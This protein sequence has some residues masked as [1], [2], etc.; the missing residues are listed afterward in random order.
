MKQ[1]K[2]V[3][4]LLGSIFLLVAVAGLTAS[5]NLQSSGESASVLSAANEDGVNLTKDLH[6]PAIAIVSHI[7]HDFVT[8]IDLETNQVTDTIHAGE[9]TCWTAKV[10]GEDELYI[11]DFKSND[12]AIVDGKSWGKCTRV[13]AGVRPS[14]VGFTPDGKTALI[15]H[16][17]QDGLW[18]VNTKTHKITAK[19][20]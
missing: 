9:G 13:P 10:P 1:S 11:A 6:H 16:E 18:F 4:S 15:S 12:V 19:I 2:E 20:S 14:C 5:G 3:V 8:V 7:S 17:S